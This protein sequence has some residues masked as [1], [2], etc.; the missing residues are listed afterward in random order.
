MTI[1]AA[2]MPPLPNRLFPAAII[3]AEHER[4]TILKTSKQPS[5]IVKVSLHSSL[6]ITSGPNGGTEVCMLA[7]APIDR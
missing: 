3:H 5:K 6:T 2:L 1:R 4:F 7:G